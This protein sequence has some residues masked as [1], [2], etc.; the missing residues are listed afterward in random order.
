MILVVAAAI[1]SIAVTGV[2]TWVLW[3]M[4]KNG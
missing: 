2:L 1:A 4:N 3:R